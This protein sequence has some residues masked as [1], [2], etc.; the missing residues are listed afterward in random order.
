MVRITIDGRTFEVQDGLTILEAA[1]QMILIYLRSVILRELMRSA[2]ARCALL[3][4][5]AEIASQRAAIRR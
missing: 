4:S 3:R 2:H 5:K 1:R